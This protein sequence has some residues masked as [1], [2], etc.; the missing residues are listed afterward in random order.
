MDRAETASKLFKA[1]RNV[2]TNTV[3]TLQ[4]R[5]FGSLLANGLKLQA[6]K[7]GTSRF[8]TT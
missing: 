8:E 7:A 5:S 4:K 2:P 1:G 6:F 3:E